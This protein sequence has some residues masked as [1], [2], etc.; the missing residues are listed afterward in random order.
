MQHKK[1]FLRNEKIVI[2]GCLV[3]WIL[4]AGRAD[5]MAFSDI[6]YE[7]LELVAPSEKSLIKKKSNKKTDP[8]IVETQEMAEPQGV[9]TPNDSNMNHEQ[10]MLEQDT[11]KENSVQ[12][13]EPV[14]EEVL[15]QDV[16]VG[17][18]ESVQLQ[19]VQ[20]QEEVMENAVEMEREQKIKEISE[21]INEIDQALQLLEQVQ[22]EEEI[23]E[24]LRS[25]LYDNSNCDIIPQKH[26]YWMIAMIVFCCY[27]I[28]ASVI[29]KIF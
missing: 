15:I 23:S 21:Q 6:P 1:S 5:I 4:M 16:T 2:T 28:L 17:S 12:Q 18:G 3:V 10:S 8:S 24:N 26:N 22:R 13:K 14:S 11:I 27:W 9:I 29:T 19:D 25:E 7:E 20:L